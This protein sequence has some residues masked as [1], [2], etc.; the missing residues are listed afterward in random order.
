MIKFESK[1]ET[2]S[3]NAFTE[4]IPISDLKDGINSTEDFFIKKKDEK[5]EWVVNRLCD[6]N[7][8]KLIIKKNE[9]GY[10]TCPIHNWKLNLNKLEY[11]NK[12]VKQK[13]KFKIKNRNIEIKKSKKTLEFKNTLKKKT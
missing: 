7:S 5:I 1:I 10:A 11:T 13:V 8:G 3:K 12:I 6:H 4:S 9:K 2:K